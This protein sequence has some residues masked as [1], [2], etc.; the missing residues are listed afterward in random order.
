[1]M[2]YFSYGSNMSPV[3]L[4]DRVPS[5][6]FVG[7]ATLKE[8]DLRFHKKS[9]DGSGKCDAY[10][11]GNEEHQIIGVVYEINEAEKPALDAKEGLNQGYDEKEV[12][13][14]FL[15]SGKAIT[16]LTYFATKIDKSLKPYEWYKYHV[17]Y[18][19]KKNGLPEEYI[20]K[21]HNIVTIEDPKQERHERE[22]EIYANN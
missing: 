8:H 9:I 12:A 7:T 4:L 2:L 1:M 15:G 17:L 3:R 10:Q 22:M 21:I 13:L 16:A 6:K 11:T 20:Q 5:A 19:A 14:T 18:G